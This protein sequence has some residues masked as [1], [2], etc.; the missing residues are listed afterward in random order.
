MGTNYFIITRSGKIYHVGKKS[1]GIKFIF[2]CSEIKMED[3]FKMIY[4]AMDIFDE[5]NNKLD[6]DELLQIIH[7]KGKTPEGTE[8]YEDKYYYLTKDFFWSAL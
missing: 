7:L 5:Y 4:Q 6:K 3:W 1:T 8:V 2:N